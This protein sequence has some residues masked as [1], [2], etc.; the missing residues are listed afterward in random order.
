MTPAPKPAPKEK[1]VPKFLARTSWGVSTK[2]RKALRAVNPAR[3]AK[4][5]KKT[6]KHYNSPEY[7]AARAERMVI[8]GGRCEVWHLSD[9]DMRLAA[10][11]LP[12]EDPPFRINDPEKWFL[13]RCPRTTTLEFHEEHYGSDV[14]MVR[15]ITGYICCDVDHQYIEMTRHPTRH[16]THGRGA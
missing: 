12:G 9:A 5:Q 1:A 11:M 16:R 10:V 2:P 6:R 13:S 3:E 15:P 8:S 4:R 14:G 7:K